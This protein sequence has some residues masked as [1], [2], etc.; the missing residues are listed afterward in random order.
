MQT[1]HGLHRSP[2]LQTLTV[3]R[4]RLSNR[5]VFRIEKE[6]TLGQATETPEFL[7][8]CLIHPCALRQSEQ[9]DQPLATERALKSLRAAG[10]AELEQRTFQGVCVDR[11]TASGQTENPRGFPKS[12][13]TGMHGGAKHI[14]ANCRG[15]VANTD[16][17]SGST[18]AG[19]F[20]WLALSHELR[21]LP[22][23]IQRCIDTD[24]NLRSM[25]SALFPKTQPAWYG[26]WLEG[27][28]GGKRAKALLHLFEKVKLETY[29]VDPAITDDLRLLEPARLVN[30]CQ[31]CANS[32]LR[33]AVEVIPRASLQ[34]RSW[35]WPPHCRRCKTPRPTSKLPCPVC[36]TNQSP[37]PPIKRKTR[38]HRPFL[39][40]K[41]FLG[42]ERSNSLL[43]IIASQVT[44]G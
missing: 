7:A 33:L 41:Q 16:P 40:L 31:K 30:A 34:D 32:S 25:V 26:L 17:S 11:E 29:A 21:Q 42:E 27:S 10:V 6:T 3:T 9:I 43:E 4:D 44:D 19:C 37:H 8:W 24:S 15:C 12:E 1:S 36:G 35:C 38:G 5:N 28:V 23:A 14:D 20:G 39:P 13:I 2:P 18:W 22:E